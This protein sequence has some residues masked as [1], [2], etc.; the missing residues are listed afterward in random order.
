MFNDEIYMLSN[1]KC[2]EILY[3]ALELSPIHK[4]CAF[5]VIKVNSKKHDLLCH[6]SS[7]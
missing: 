2:K 5:E 7:N 3:K 1:T 4:L 6:N